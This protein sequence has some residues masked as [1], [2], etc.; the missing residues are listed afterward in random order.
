M[1]STITSKGQL[2]VPKA[3]REKYGLQS[4]DKVEFLDDPELGLRI[5]P[6][7]QPLSR[8]KGMVPKPDKAISLEDM[9]NAIEYEGSKL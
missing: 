4:G 1:T 9:Q 6:V 7:T 8:L 2:T 5:V 3:I